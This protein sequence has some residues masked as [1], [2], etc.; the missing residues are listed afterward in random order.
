MTRESLWRELDNRPSGDICPRALVTCSPD[1]VYSLPFLD[2]VF[3]ILPGERKILPGREGGETAEDELILL[4]LHY[5]LNAKELPLSAR[6]VSEKE[7]TGGSL[8]FQGP[9]RIP[10]HP[11]IERYGADTASFLKRGEFLG[12]STMEYGDAS[13]CFPALPRIP[14][15]F[16]MWEADEEFPAN[17]TVLFD[18]SIES[19]MALDVILALVNQMVK[20]IVGS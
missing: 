10:V 4:F 14:A 15:G 6:W 20:R 1:G 3:R 18:A 5:L 13:L 8:F 12:G 7:L 19:H 9:H 17:A 2:T 16:V 11:L